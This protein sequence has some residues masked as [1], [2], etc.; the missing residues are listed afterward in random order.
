M[1][2]FVPGCGSSGNNSTVTDAKAVTSY[3]LNGANAAIDESA[4]T[5]AVTVPNETDVTA[6]VATYTTTGK[7]VDVGLVEQLSGSTPNDFTLPVDYLVTAVDDSVTTYTVT[8][9]VSSAQGPD[10]VNLGTAGNFVILAKSAVS[11]TGTTAVVGDIGVS[12]AA[13]SYI[14]GFSLIADST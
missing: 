7:F 14:T 1:I 5:I 3:S 12:P 4:K 8:V 6:L 11:T 13:A 10:P 2:T 9:I